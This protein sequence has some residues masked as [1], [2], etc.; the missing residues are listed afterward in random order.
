MLFRSHSLRQQDV[1]KGFGKWKIYYSQ[2]NLPY[3]EGVVRENIVERF[4]KSL[5]GFKP[6]AI[7]RVINLEN[8]YGDGVVDKVIWFDPSVL[9][10]VSPKVLFD[11]LDE[12]PMIVIKGDNPLAKMTNKKAKDWFGV[13]DKD[14][15]GI[16]HIGGTMYAFNFNDLNVRKCFELWK[17][18]EENGIFGTQDEFMTGLH[19]AD[20]SCMA[21]AMYKTGIE[22]YTEEKFTFLNQKNL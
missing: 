19:W 17:E 1:I 11:S 6:H 10:T 7:S 5:Y 12:H 4:Q 18:A 3:S 14:I 13:T 20:E 15:E 16:N 22:Q 8:E 9:P 21:L 2:D